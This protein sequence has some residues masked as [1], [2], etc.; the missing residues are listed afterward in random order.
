MRSAKLV[1]IGNNVESMPGFAFYFL[2]RR[3]MAS[4]YL[5]IGQ[6]FG[7]HLVNRRPMSG[8]MTFFDIAAEGAFSAK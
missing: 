2:G 5:M 3:E 6:L 7:G 4:W 1:C 8:E